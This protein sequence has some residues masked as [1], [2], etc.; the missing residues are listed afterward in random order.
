[1]MLITAALILIITCG[2]ALGQD[3]PD[4]MTYSLDMAPDSVD[5]LYDGCSR[6]MTDQVQTCYLNREISLPGFKK[7]WRDGEENYLEP[8]DDLTRNH[9]IAINVYTGSKVH[10][11]FNNA[12]RSGKHAY[13]LQAFKWYSLH[14]WLTEAIQILKKTQQECKLTYRG[15][16]VS[17]KQS[18]VLNKEI[19]F[20]SF[21]SSSLDQNETRKFGT[22]YCFEIFTCHGADISIYSQHPA[23]KEVLIPPYEKFIITDI[24]NDQKDDWCKTVYTLSSSGIKS[25]LNCAGGPNY[26]PFF[27]YCNPYFSSSSKH[28][29]FHPQSK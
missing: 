21:T 10:D 17:F 19:R 1:M 8:Q 12:V 11:E 5:D 6:H 3:V 29:T 24:R 28:T 18:L 20:G 22:L 25:N 15:T 7:A 26:A 4:E 14:F 23:E 13:R 27:F 2:I 9:S 16:K